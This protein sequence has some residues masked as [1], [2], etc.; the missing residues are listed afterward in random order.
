MYMMIR[1]NVASGA[2]AEQNHFEKTTSNGKDCND[3]IVISLE[4]VPCSYVP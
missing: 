4:G 3:Q 1:K 2:T